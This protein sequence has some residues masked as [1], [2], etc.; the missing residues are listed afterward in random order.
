[1]NLKRTGTRLEPDGV[2]DSFEQFFG[3]LGHGFY[4]VDWYE[5]VLYTLSIRSDSQSCVDKNIRN[6]K[7]FSS[8]RWVICGKN[9]AINPQMGVLYGVDF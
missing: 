8:R 5:K 7:Y 3:A 9:S 2:G 4:L 6:I 1:M